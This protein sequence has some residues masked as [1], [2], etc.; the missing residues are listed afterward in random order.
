[1]DFIAYAERV[2]GMC[3]DDLRNESTISI[4]NI[5]RYGWSFTFD[6]RMVVEDGM[7][8]QNFLENAKEKISEILDGDGFDGPR[9]M[10]GGIELAKPNYL[11]ECDALTI[12]EGIQLRVYAAVPPPN[13]I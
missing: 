3:E 10:V 13:V 1:M 12:G 5:S 4:I 11:N 9:A 6:I 2:M 7:T 8:P